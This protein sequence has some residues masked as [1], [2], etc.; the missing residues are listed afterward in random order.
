MSAGNCLY[1]R[2]EDFRQLEARNIWARN[3]RNCA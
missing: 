1:R 2:T 3:L